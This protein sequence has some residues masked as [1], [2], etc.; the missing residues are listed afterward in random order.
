MSGIRLSEFSSWFGGDQTIEKK[1]VSICDL[2]VN[3]SVPVDLTAAAASHSGT[4]LSR[5]VDKQTADVLTTAIA[6]DSQ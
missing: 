4:N 6:P 2:T 5:T 3:V 1:I